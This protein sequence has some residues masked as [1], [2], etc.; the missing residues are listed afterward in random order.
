MAARRPSP[1]PRKAA[2]SS[3]LLHRACWA[4]AL[5]TEVYRRGPELAAL[6]PLGS[7]PEKSA[8]ALLAAA[9]DVALDQL[10]QIGGAFES[11]LLPALQTRTGLWALGPV[12]AGSEIMNADADLIAGSLLLELKTT[13]KKPS[14]GVTDLWQVLGYA[15]MDYTDEFGISDVAVFQARY[16]HLAEWNL[17]E[18]LT[19]LAGRATT[20]AE[21]REEFRTL[22][23]A[24][25]S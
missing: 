2:A 9:S 13:A 21:L 20:A 4:L 5:L 10:A 19:Q 14:L 16:C 23:Q 3:E 7:L 24:C 12:F 17:D 6:G 18:L 22:L 1:G 11:A 8:D 25:R 15:L